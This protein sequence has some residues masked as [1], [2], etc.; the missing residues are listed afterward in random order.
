MKHVD[1][2]LKSAHRV[3]LGATL[4]VLAGCSSVP[5]Q[6][7]EGKVH[8]RTFN[9]MASKKASVPAFADNRAEMHQS[10]QVA[11]SRNLASKG[12]QKVDAGG[13]LIVG[14]L[15]IVAS[16]VTTTSIGDYFGYGPDN[17]A[18]IE[19]AH[20]SA[21]ELRESG[22]GYRIRDPKLYQAGALVVDILDAKTL[23]LQYRNFTHR[24][25]LPAGTPDEVR[26]KR[27]QEAVD[28]I[29]ADLRVTPGR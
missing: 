26:T 7:N 18:L 2:A 21:Q 14:Y 29:L 27:L 12:L 20:G 22:P 8:A 11:I 6:V 19:K 17:A 28:E 23:G 5:V 4:A 9:F 25:L 15:V 3:L 16:N 13:D 24:D 10:I 1:V